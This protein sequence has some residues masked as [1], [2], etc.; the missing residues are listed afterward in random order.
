[1]KKGASVG[2]FLAVFLLTLVLSFAF[3]GSILICVNNFVEVPM[4]P[5]LW[6]CIGFGVILAIVTSV[7]AIRGTKQI[8]KSRF[9]LWMSKH[10]PKLLISYFLLIFA[11][12]SIESQPIWAPEEISD[13]LSI[14]WTIFGLSLT[15]FLV[16]DVV[17]VDFLKKRQPK[18]YDPTDLLQKYRSILEKESFSQDVETTFSTVILLTVNLFLLLLSTTLI[19]IS[20]QSDTIFT[21]NVLHCSFFF[22]TNSIA[23]LFLDILK[24]LQKEKADMLKRSN[25]SM[26]DI[27]NANAAMLAQAIIDGTKQAVM[28]LD[29]EKYTYEEKEKMIVEYLEAFRDLFCSSKKPEP[30]EL[31]EKIS[32]IGG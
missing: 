23:F 13:V 9:S 28:G 5:W 7:W 20:A 4:T 16:W 10:Y 32:Q 26:E 12:I 6:C 1:M 30:E 15:I 24:P 27:D 14:Q 8:N 19:Y 3:T 17:I 25:V 31:K 21:Q 11:L 18:E 2:L 29:P 22:T